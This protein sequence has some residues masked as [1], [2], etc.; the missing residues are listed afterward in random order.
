[1]PTNSSLFWISFETHS[2]REDNCKFAYHAKE[3]GSLADF[4]MSFIQQSSKSTG[5]T[6]QA[7]K[8]SEKHANKKTLT[9]IWDDIAVYCSY[10]TTHCGQWLWHYIVSYFP[11]LAPWKLYVL[12]YSDQVFTISEISVSEKADKFSFDLWR[13]LKV[14]F[15]SAVMRDWTLGRNGTVR[16]RAVCA[17]ERHLRIIIS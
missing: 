8:F 3:F 13:I 7:S 15:F 2:Y 14:A 16:V 1:M 12:Y 17:T 10:R 9:Y 4:I 11:M 6:W 5:Q